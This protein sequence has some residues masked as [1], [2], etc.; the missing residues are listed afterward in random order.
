MEPF[1][2]EISPLPGCALAWLERRER[3]VRG[4]QNILWAGMVV[5]EG[6]ESCRG[7]VLPLYLPRS[8]V[9]PRRPDLQAHMR[10]KGGNLGLRMWS[11]L[12]PASAASEPSGSPG[13]FWA[14]LE[15]QP[16]LLGP[17]SISWLVFAG[18]RCTFSPRWYPP[19]G[20][21]SSPIIS[22]TP[23]CRS[24]LKRIPCSLPYFDP[25]KAWPVKALLSLIPCRLNYL[26]F[27]RVS[28]F[29]GMISSTSQSK[30]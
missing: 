15:T 5:R 14:R 19:V 17:L 9:M 24:L 8:N 16:P 11:W 1:G 12:H 21:G 2:G 20:H 22:I 7:H 29:S 6:M 27:L 26:L 23:T 25:A 3:A 13:P 28:W 18:I 10:N 4:K 30:W